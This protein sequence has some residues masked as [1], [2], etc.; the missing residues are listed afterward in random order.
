MEA[1]YLLKDDLASLRWVLKAAS[2]DSSRPAL[3]TIHIKNGTLITTDGFRIHRW[4]FPS[5]SIFKT[6]DDK[7]IEGHYQM[8]IAGRY[9]IFEHLDDSAFGWVNF[10][11]I[12][13]G[14]TFKTYQ[15]AQTFKEPL[16]HM[17]VNPRLMSDSLHGLSTAAEIRIGYL[18]EILDAYDEDRGIFYALI[19]PMM[20][21]PILLDPETPY[22]QR[23]TNQEH[24]DFM[25][26]FPKE[27]TWTI[28]I[29]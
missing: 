2:K 13:R 20:P 8:V 29:F 22:P 5:S 12:P 18:I 10:D 1:I 14:K 23:S 4:R 27:N 19:M 9:L 7:F 6:Y 28:K 15:A 26:S 17:T 3:Q 21:H 11:A 25:R 16:L 24:W